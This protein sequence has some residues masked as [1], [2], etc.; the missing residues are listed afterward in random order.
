[1][2][3]KH[4]L[5]SSCVN[6]HTVKGTVIFWAW[7][8]WRVYASLSY[9]GISK[10]C[11]CTWHKTSSSTSPDDM[12][13]QWLQSLNWY[14]RVFFLF[15]IGKFFSICEIARHHVLILKPISNRAIQHQPILFCCTMLPIAVAVAAQKSLP[16]SCHHSRKVA[17]VPFNRFCDVFS[18]TLNCSIRLYS[19]SSL[20]TWDLRLQVSML[21]YLFWRSPPA[22]LNSIWAAGIFKPKWHSP[23]TRNSTAHS[24]LV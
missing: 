16:P 1:M 21:G 13:A 2:C 15:F 9:F 18:W 3:Q 8:I 12:I 14:C 23:L 6:V 5:S 22:L 7:C 4:G 19:Y 10:D 20:G 17:H 24:Y 11:C